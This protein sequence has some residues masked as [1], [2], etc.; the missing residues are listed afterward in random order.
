MQDR[1][2]QSIPAYLADFFRTYQTELLGTLICLI[3][4]YLIRFIIVKGIK[5]IGRK[6]QLSII[7]T[8]LVVRY[9]AMLLGLINLSFII[10]IWGVPLEKLGVVISSTFAVIGVALFATW[11]ILSNITAGIILFFYYPFKIGDRIRILDKDFPDEATIL[12]I[13]AFNVILVKDNGEMLT[14]PNNLLLQKGA[15]LLG[16]QVATREELEMDF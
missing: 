4:F 5:R 2:Q 9:V 13:K 3:V 7:R 16:K 11:S 6:S 15:G 12:D 14:Y 8:R 1:L 10:V